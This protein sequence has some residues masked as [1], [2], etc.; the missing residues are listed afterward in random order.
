MISL[1]RIGYFGEGRS[2]GEQGG[3]HQNLQLL[4]GTCVGFQFL[5]MGY[6]RHS[7]MIRIFYLRSTVWTFFFNL[8]FNFYERNT[9]PF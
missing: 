1:T 6:L 3:G 5:S 2:W 7:L 4:W 9:F 8:N